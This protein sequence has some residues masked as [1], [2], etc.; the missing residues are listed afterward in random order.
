MEIYIKDIKMP[1]FEHQSWDIRKGT[2]KKWYVVDTNAE[3]SD[4]VWHEIVP[5]PPHG[6]LVDAD[7]VSLEGGPYEYDEWCKWALDQYLNAPTIIP[8]EPLKEET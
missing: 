2:D 8:A 4:G 6:R 7:A 3:T 1:V 5:I